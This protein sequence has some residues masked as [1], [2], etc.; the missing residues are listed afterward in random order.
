M[1]T[2]ISAS[3]TPTFPASDVDDDSPPRSTGAL[4]GAHATV[5]R[6][7]SIQ[8]QDEQPRPVDGDHLVDLAGRTLAAEGYPPQTELSI[9]LVTDAV[10]AEYNRSAF[11]RQGPTDVLA[12]PLEDL[13]PGRPPH[14]S[15]G[16]PPLAVGDVV[17]AP[18]YVE[19]QAGE[20]GVEPVH[21]LSLMVVH[22]VLHLL[23]YDHVA[24]AD[25][26]LMEARESEIL[27]GVGVA[28]R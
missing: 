5:P 26:E 2:T 24:D 1:A 10:M 25:A 20:L 18:A 16:G 13:E 11:G 22:G 3:P 23:G 12:F 9:L 21:E 19:R 7:P 15:D 14:R 17:I 8:L 28:R 4:R 6:G 27:S